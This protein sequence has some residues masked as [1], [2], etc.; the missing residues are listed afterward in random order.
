MAI[1]VYVIVDYEYPRA[2]MIRLEST[3]QSLVDLRHQ[4]N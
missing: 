2:G 1:T 3:D 4:M